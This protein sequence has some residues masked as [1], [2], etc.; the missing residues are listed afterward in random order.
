[1]FWKYT[2]NETK[3]LLNI[4]LLLFATYVIFVGQ[5]WKTVL[6]EERNL[7]ANTVGVFAG[8]E[9]NEVNTLT[10]QLDTREKELDARELALTQA[11]IIAQK[12]LLS[13]MLLA[14]GALFGLILLNF[15]LD[16]KRR[17]S[18]PAM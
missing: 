10:A 8:V 9:K 11:N 6:I 17:L 14:G 4:T 12:K 2:R 16:H 18:I 15:Y 5:S 1:M 3:T 7:V 13:S